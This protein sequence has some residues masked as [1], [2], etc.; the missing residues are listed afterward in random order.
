M[1][2]SRFLWKLYAGYVFLILLATGIVG[3]LLA[4]RIESDTLADIDRGLRA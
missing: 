3:T 2:R 4:V 1:R